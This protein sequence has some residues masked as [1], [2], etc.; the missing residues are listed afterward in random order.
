MWCNFE[1]DLSSSLRINIDHNEITFQGIVL[2]GKCF[3]KVHKMC[4]NKTAKTAKKQISG[5]IKKIESDGA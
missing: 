4:E 5:I 2:Y 1:F 3:E